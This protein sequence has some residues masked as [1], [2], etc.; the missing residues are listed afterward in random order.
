MGI[1][2]WRHSLEQERSVAVVE[3]KE[4]KEMWRNLKKIWWD[5]I[6]ESD[7]AQPLLTPPALTAPSIVSTIWQKQQF[8]KWYY[9]NWYK[10]PRIRFVTFEYVLC[11]DRSN[12]QPLFYLWRLTVDNHRLGKQDHCIQMA[13]LGLAWQVSCLTTKK[14]ITPQCAIVLSLD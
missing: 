3:E 5:P 14:N 8:T 1:S 11:L 7:H 12:Y 2:I 6:F 10:M 4:S 9:R 13:V